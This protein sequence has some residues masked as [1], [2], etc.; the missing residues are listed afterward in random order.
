VENQVKSNQIK[1]SA[2]VQNNPIAQKISKTSFLIKKSKKIQK[3]KQKY[4]N[5]HKN[6]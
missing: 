5:Y 2:S 3:K 1:Q 6:Q 4:Q